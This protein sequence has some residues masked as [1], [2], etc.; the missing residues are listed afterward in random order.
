MHLMIQKP[1]ALAREEIDIE[2]WNHT[3]ESSTQESIYGYSHTLDHLCEHWDGLVLDD[4]RAVMPLPWR[5][6]FGI[7]YAFTPAFIQRLDVY[8]NDVNKEQ[9]I[10]FSEVLESMFLYADVDLGFTAPGMKQLSPRVNYIKDLTSDYSVIYDSYTSEAVRNL[11]KASSR[12]CMYVE[13]VRIEDVITLY[14]SAFG[15]KASYNEA[16]YAKVSAFAHYCDRSGKL[17]LRGV[18]HAVTKE[19]LFDALMFLS[20]KRVYYL[21]GAPTPD[22]RAARAGYCL[23][24]GV[25][26]EFAGS[27]HIFDF[28]GS[29]IPS[30]AS[31]YQKFSPGT[32]QYYHLHINRLPWPL[33]MFK[34]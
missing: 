9:Q 26:Q 29:D 18:R 24:D 23:I 22:G 10:A 1:L 3:V 34:R 16:D 17:L 6:K 27:N 12:N 14:R 19:L 5:K 13:D 7:R 20:A 11:R 2:R 33:K 30:V 4:Y 21:L 32:E 28:E 31:F 8:G 25:F 15:L